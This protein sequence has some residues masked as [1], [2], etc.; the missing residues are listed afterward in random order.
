MTYPALRS[1]VSESQRSKGAAKKCCRA[2]P[3]RRTCAKQKTLSNSARGYHQQRGTASLASAGSPR[4]LC[5]SA[6][7][8]LPFPRRWMVAMFDSHD[9][10]D[11]VKATES[12]SIPLDDAVRLGMP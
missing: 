7:V 10:E 8:E 9:R 11:W 12:E 3:K 2:S 5:T 4:S 1:K 6:T